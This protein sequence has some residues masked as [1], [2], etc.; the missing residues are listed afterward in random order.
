[1]ASESLQRR[2]N[3]FLDRASRSERYARETKDELIREQF[4][5]SARKWRELAR[6]AQEFVAR[7]YQEFD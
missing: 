5:G 4:M 6:T 3:E 2:A 7:G 1:V